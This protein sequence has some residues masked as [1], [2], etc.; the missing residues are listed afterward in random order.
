MNRGIKMTTNEN[1][2]AIGTGLKGLR[3]IAKV[4]GESCERIAELTLQYAESGE[5]Y[6]DRVTEALT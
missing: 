5:R 2:R 3:E 1:L 6:A 4:H